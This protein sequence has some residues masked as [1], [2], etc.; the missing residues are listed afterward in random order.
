[1]NAITQETDLAA[2]QAHLSAEVARLQLLQ[3]E[4]T[5]ERFR[6]LEAE[7][8]RVV[9]QCRTAKENLERCR[10]E[11][12]RYGSPAGLYLKSTREL[13]RVQTEYSNHS[14]N[15][16]HPSTYPSTEELG[17][18]DAR[19]AELGRE[20]ESAE[21]AYRQTS[22][23]YEAVKSARNQARDAFE[24]LAATE[25]ELRAQLHPKQ[26][27]RGITSEV[28]DGVRP[29]AAYRRADTIGNV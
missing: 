6:R 4:I 7:H 16:P 27:G 29:G 13:Q 11:A 23:E 9:D 15:P 10:E 14:L 26:N 22:L 8:Q 5:A 1:M 21:Q 20:F 2:A 24:R 17:A 18:W 28:M 12:D 25:A 3:Q 19:R